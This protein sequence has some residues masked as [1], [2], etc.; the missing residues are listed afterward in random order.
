M[1]GASIA[2]RPICRAAA[3]APTRALA[4]IAWKSLGFDFTETRSMLVHN[5]KDGSWDAGELRE[6]FTLNIHA[7]SNVLHY[8]QAI[9][10]GLK[11]FHCADGKVRV[12]NSR[13]NAQRLHNGCVR[14][15]MPT[16]DPEM[17]D[18]AIDRVIKENVDFVP[19][20]GSGGALY[21]RPFLFGHGAKIGLGPAPEYGFCIAGIP[22]GAYYKGGL[23][24]ID[25]LVVEQFDRAA[26]RGVGNI[27][28]AGNYAP[29]VQPAASA[30]EQGYPS[31]STSTRRPTRTWRSSRRPTLSA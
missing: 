9:F 15:H 13:A 29:D 31:A 27:K 1:L 18:A 20:Y 17:F 5:W 8:G 16:V 21:L 30:K 19:P 4:S 10:E 14:L 28:A 3:A 12:F 25:A 24:A 11:A 23:E 2:R 6:D 7:M 22:V 26:P